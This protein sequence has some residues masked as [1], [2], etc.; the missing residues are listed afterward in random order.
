MT[1]WSAIRIPAQGVQGIHHHHHKERRMSEP[2]YVQLVLDYFAARPCQE[3]TMT[4]FQGILQHVVHTYALLP[5]IVAA[6]E[7]RALEVA[8]ARGYLP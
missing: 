3:R 6:V 2:F 8:R 7:A 4:T 5:S 1:R